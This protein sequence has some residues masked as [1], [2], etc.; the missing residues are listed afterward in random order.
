MAQGNPYAR[1]LEMM[2]R[3]GKHFNGHDMALAQVLSVEP[4]SVAV[5]G[6]AIAEHIY[7]NEITNS[8]KDEEIAEI[9]ASEENISP[10]L[11][12]FLKELYEGIRVKPGDYVLVQR[13]ENSFY[14]CGK[15]VSV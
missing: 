10:R 5:N 4:I 12:T 15:V 14:V 8:D 3:Q 13:V 11:K 7:C 2:K 9:L 1:M 6:Q